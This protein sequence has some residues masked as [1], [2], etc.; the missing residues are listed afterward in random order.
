[1]T[2]KLLE[3]TNLLSVVGTFLVAALLCAAALGRW[4]KGAPYRTMVRFATLGAAIPIALYAVSIL[5]SRFGLRF[6]VTVEDIFLMLWPGSIATMALNSSSGSN[7]FFIV[8]LIL[9]NAG[10]YGVVG[11]CIGLTW[12]LVS[13]R[14]FQ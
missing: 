10:L 2:P 3:V 8:I 13:A 1:M 5:D 7:L 14:R 11:L 4:K 6:L 9:M 12:M